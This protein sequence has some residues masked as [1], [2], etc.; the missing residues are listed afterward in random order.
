[1]DRLTYYWMLTSLSHNFFMLHYDALPVE[2]VDEMN[3]AFCTT[4]NFPL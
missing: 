4:C 2:C 3:D 1:M